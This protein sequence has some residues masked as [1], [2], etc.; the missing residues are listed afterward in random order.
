MY[1]LKRNRRLR[2]KKSLRNL[3]RETTI[4]PHDFI[5][6][7]FLVEGKNIKDEIPSMPNYYRF[8]LDNISK[9][10]KQLWDLGVQAVLL[11]AKV[12]ESLKDNYGTEA[13]NNA[14]L[15]QRGIKEIKDCVPE[16]TIMTDVALDPYSNFGH[17]GVV[18]NNEII[19]D[20]TNEILSRMALSHATAGA[21]VVAP[22]DMMDGRVLSIRN[23]LEKNGFHHTGIMSYAVKYASNFYGPFRDA[24]D[25]KPGFGDKETYQMDFANK[26][27]S[28]SEAKADIEEGADIIMV[29]PG[30]SY[31]D[32]LRDL[33]NN[34]NSP[35]A[36][37]QVSGE[38]SMLKAAAQKG[39]LDH[40][41]VMLE[42]LISMKR[43]GATMIASYF[44]KDA[45]KLL[46]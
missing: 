29:K 11:F 16:I 23:T 5:V 6:P 4:H 2:S 37:Y 38:Y 3:V 15:M 34:I 36:I 9:E 42:Q 14:G 44:A 8:S 21:D 20:K 27:D 17:D 41:K 12:P 25:S 45:I 32:I 24:L 46:S 1:P 30:I 18:E 7:L 22:S 31:L 40:D 13:L 28:V 33:K 19:N 26:F 10:V 39:W 35:I 43:A